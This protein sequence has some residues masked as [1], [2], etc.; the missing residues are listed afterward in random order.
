MTDHWIFDLSTGKVLYH[1]E[2][3]EWQLFSA[4]QNSCSLQRS[5]ER[6]KDKG[7]QLN[8][9]PDWS[10]LQDVA[11]EIREHSEDIAQETEIQVNEWIK[12]KNVKFENLKSIGRYLNAENYIRLVF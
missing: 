6:H 12:E 7:W 10:C 1:M 3:K 2:P 11:P 4:E 9:P 8:G 5:R